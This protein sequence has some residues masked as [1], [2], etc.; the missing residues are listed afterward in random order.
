MKKTK[1]FTLIVLG[2]LL[3]AS[4]C[5]ASPIHVLAADSNEQ[6]SGYAHEDI[7]PGNNSAEVSWQ[8]AYVEWAKSRNEDGTVSS[9]DSNMNEGNGVGQITAAERAQVRSGAIIEIPF[10]E[11][12]GPNVTADKVSYEIGIKVDEA[13]ARLALTLKWFGYTQG[14]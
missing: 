10:N 14:D 9:V 13:L 6:Y 3:T 11:H 4:I 8:A 1:L 5:Q 7:P 12:F 2:L